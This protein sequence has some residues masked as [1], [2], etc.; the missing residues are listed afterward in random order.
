MSYA[1]KIRIKDIA[2]MA[3]VSVGTVDR[4]IHGRNN[5]SRLALAKVQ[6]VLDEIDYVPNHYASALASNKVYNFAIVLPMHEEDSYWARVEIGLKEGIKRF[7]DF[8]ID[9]QIFSYDQ[10]NDSTFEVQAKLALESN[11]DAVIIGPIFN[12]HIMAR[13]V[14]ELE[15]KNIPYSLIDS[16]WADFNPVCFYGQDSKKSGEFSAKIMLMA[17]GNSKKIAIFKLMG[18][19]RVASRQQLDR[20]TGF[21]GYIAKHSPETEIITLNLYVYDKD[22][23]KQALTKFFKDN[24]DIRHGLTFNSSVHLI[25]NFL[26]NELPDFP[27]VTLLGYDAINHNVECIKN[28]SVEFL[29]AQQPQRQ[30]MYTFRTTFN[31]TVLKM[32]Q[33]QVVHYVP[34][35]LLTIENLDFYED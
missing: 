33:K 16:Y 3:G 27:H 21:R 25:G 24:P 18:E 15:A 28:G 1:S 11:P 5:V 13:F 32:A 26:T 31:A 2:D 35:E 19:G 9:S 20:E 10:F 23:V 12:H 8:K 4:V 14:K 17:A 6:K 29:I 7:N 30:G 34:I 22:G